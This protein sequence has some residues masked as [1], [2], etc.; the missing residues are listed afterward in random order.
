MGFKRGHFLKF[1]SKIA[2][3]NHIKE[4]SS[5]EN[6]LTSREMN[7]VDI[8][9][10]CLEKQRVVQPIARNNN[11]NNP[12]LEIKQDDNDDNQEIII[13]NENIPD[14]PQFTVNCLHNSCDIKVN[15][16]ESRYVYNVKLY[17]QI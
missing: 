15:Q 4:F 11:N 7:K 1:Q 14:I 8:W 2:N 5:L 12:D 10:K 17:K 13:M 6:K 3:N 16:L 9:K